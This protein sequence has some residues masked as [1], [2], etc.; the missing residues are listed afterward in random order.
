MRKALPLLVLLLICTALAAQ[1][2]GQDSV[3]EL[4]RVL[5]YDPLNDSLRLNLAWNLMLLEQYEDALREYRFVARRDSSSVDAATGILWAL[6]SQKLHREAVSEANSFLDLM[7]QSGQ[8]YYHR[9]IAR[10]KLGKASKSRQDEAE[11]LKL[12]EEPYWKELAAIALSD[13]YLAMDDLP[14]ARAV[15]KKHAPQAANPRGYRSL[16]IDAT[17]G[18][19]ADSTAIY[20]VGLKTTLGGTRLGIKAEDLRIGGDH[21]RWYFHAS[22]LQQFRHLD[23]MAE[24]RY[25]D[26]DDARMY[27]AQGAGLC[28]TPRIYAGPVIIRPRISQSALQTQRLNSYQSEAGLKLVI[29]SFKLDYSFSYIYLDKDIV[30]SDSSA[31]V[32]SGEISTALGRGFELGFYGG[33]G[34]MAFYSTSYGGVI[35]DFEPSDGFAG[36]SFYAPV[37][38]R[39]GLLLYGQLSFD[40]EGNTSFYYIRGSY[41]V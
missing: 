7:P 4:R 28:L 16:T 1:T 25:L 40:P 29:A 39:L 22:L 34:D 20:A 13:A 10:L 2:S 15:L 37:G 41:R 8:L 17:W 12:L 3:A 19:K 18:R 6:N 21:F 32:H 23:I 35:D 36:L 11:A 26:G 24:A 38:K 30:D 14:S 33:S 9:G 5:A 31:M 27:P